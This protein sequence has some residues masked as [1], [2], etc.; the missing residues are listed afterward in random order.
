MNRYHIIFLSSFAVFLFFLTPNVNTGDGG[1]LV[2]AAYFLG[3]A[4]PSS[5][6]LYSLI[7]KTAT[8]LPLGNTAFRVALLSSVF[9]ALSLTLIYRLML[10]ITSSSAASFFSVSTLLISYSYF[11]QSV[12]AKFYP[13]N[14]FLILL[15]FSIWAAQV[16]H[17]HTGQQEPDISNKRALYL[18]SF[19]AGLITAN[20]HTG[21]IILGAAFL[22]WL[23][24]KNYSLSLATLFAGAAL[25]FA[26]FLINSYLLIRGGQDHFF[27]AVNITNLTEFYKVL[28]RQAYN[29]SGT[30]SIAVNSFRGLISYW[31]ALKN[32]LSVVTSNFSALSYF[33]F[34]A[35]CFY[36]LKRELKLLII[37]L[38]SLLLYG[39]FIAKMTLVSE[40]SSETD[41]YIVA[42]QYFIPALSFF[43]VMLGAGFAQMEK[44]LQYSGLK[45]LP[46]IVPLLAI[47]PLVFLIARAADS[48]FRTNFVPYQITKDSYS[49]LPADSVLITFGDNASY[50]GWYM[51]L[52]GR[53]REDVCQISASDQSRRLWNFQGCNQK[54]YGNVFPM[55]YSRKFTEMAPALL[56]LRLYGTDP[57]KDNAAY[58]DYMSSSIFSTDYL[59]LPKDRFINGKIKKKNITM[60]MDER[61][62]IADKV[63][64]PS[65]CLT[66]FTD[67][68]FSRQLCS[69]YII[70]L[71]NMARRYSG[72]VY[73]RTGE[74]VEVAVRD[75]KTGYK[76]PLYTVDV[77]EKN[78]PYLELSTHIQEFN[79]WKIFYL[80]EKE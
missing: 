76:L 31:Y 45:L 44:W 66:H 73:K 12:V 9:S 33:L 16:S 6:P 57:I 19:L 68:L 36:L 5:Y 51:K 4:H 56:K 17:S 63:I 28:S 35:G 47:F 62:I 40:K 64:N 75:T 74:K 34:S 50:Q 41:F 29:E 32:F 58:A 77:T 65:A 79:Q 24:K 55:F 59:Y 2:T 60:Y 52:V 48:N 22:A 10:K 13:L 11:A 78:K 30:I 70:H 15:I 25:F 21:I 37:I 80:R 14:L 46:R 1:E 71:T 69:S 8:F 49:V 53:Y 67:D 27:N 72:E 43:V 42:H 39:P 38:A 54:I 7:G 18:T 23:L 26:G 3:T 20:H 61:Q